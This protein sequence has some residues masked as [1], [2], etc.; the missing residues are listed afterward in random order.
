MLKSIWFLALLGV[1]LGT[2]TTAGVILLNKDAL[3][4]PSGAKAPR[5]P[6]PANAPRD[7]IFL[8]EEIS[9]LAGDLRS[10]REAL[11]ER[12][13]GLDQL[14]ARLV[15]ERDELRKVRA[16]LEGMRREVTESIPKVEAAEKQNIKTLAKTY[17]SMKPQDA[18]SVLREMDDPQVVKLLASMKPENV[19]AIFQEMAKAKDADGTL[20]ARAAKISDQLRLVQNEAK[21]ATQP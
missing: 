16:E 2:A 5:L 20:A 21:T 17:S 3:S 7:W 8:T 19:G 11:E 15:S 10:E 13:K 14:E 9:T 6:D 18:V 1:V 12:R 4:A